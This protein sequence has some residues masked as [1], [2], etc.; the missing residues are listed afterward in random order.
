MNISKR[1]IPLLRENA[2]V[3]IF[4]GP[5]LKTPMC[6]AD[7]GETAFL[8]SAVTACPTVR[9]LAARVCVSVGL[10]GASSYDMEGFSYRR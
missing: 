8:G 3:N 5:L 9:G 4:K 2:L 6:W 7:L 10:L 1:I